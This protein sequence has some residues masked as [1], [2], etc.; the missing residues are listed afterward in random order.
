MGLYK[1]CKYLP[2][3]FF[4]VAANSNTYAQGN[5]PLCEGYSPPIWKNC[6]GILAFPGGDK[7]KGEWSNGLGKG[8]FIF[9]DGRPE[10]NGNWENNSFIRT[11]QINLLAPGQSNITP[12]TKPVKPIDSKFKVSKLP[13]CRGPHSKEGW[14][15]CVGTYNFSSGNIYVGE[16]KNG[17]LH[18]IGTLT[19]YG[20]KYVGEFKNN[21]KNGFGTFFYTN[22]NIQEGVWENNFLVR[23]DKFTPPSQANPALDNER[24]K[25]EDDRRQLA[26]ERRRLEEEKLKSI[27]PTPA[28]PAIVSSSNGRRLALV[29]GNSSYSSVPVLINSTND[30]REVAKVL[31]A[32]GFEVSKYENIDYRQMQDAVRSFGEKLG[33][34]DVGL[35]YFAGHGVQV[36]GKNYL[37]PV[38]EN[39][40]KAFEIPTSALDADLVLATMENAKNN[41]NIV[42]LDACRSPFPGEGRSGPRGLATLDAAKGTLIAFASAPGKEAMDGKGGNS[43]YT[44]NLVKVMQQK[45]LTIEQVFK[46]VRIAV[47][48]ET[49]GEQ[50]P[51]ENSSIMGEFYFRK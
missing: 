51:W 21:S 14:S 34:N 16:W 4:L 3:L 32:S 22:G 28:A 45:G 36:K 24:K 19:E 47:V 30:A 43:P 12:P 8:V 7:F 27:V 50:V 13:P 29:I 1:V 5:L 39:I 26:E 25:L 41:L 42:I 18:G 37:I 20:G 49:N 2:L 46:Q 10:Q 33:K 15:N 11:E 23:T 6:V 35:F 31:Q 48:S 9:A 40:K 38:K 44:K 17:E